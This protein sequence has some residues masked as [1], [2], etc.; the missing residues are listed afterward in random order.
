MRRDFIVLFEAQR[1]VGAEIV[2][3]NLRDHQVAQEPNGI[4]EEPETRYQCI[5]NF[6]GKQRL[7]VNSGKR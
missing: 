3:G 7:K 1:A 2:V 6:V 5:R 4:G